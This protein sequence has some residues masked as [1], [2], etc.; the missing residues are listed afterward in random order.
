MDVYG[1]PVRVLSLEGLEK[2]KRAAGRL[3]D[4]AVLA[5]IREIRRQTGR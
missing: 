1:R 2:A 3:K 4:L 5:E